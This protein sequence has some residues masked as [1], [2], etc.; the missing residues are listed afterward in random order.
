MQKMWEGR[1]KEAS[2]KLLEDFNASISFDKALYKEDINGSIAHATMLCEC[3]ILTNDEKDKICN[4]LNQILDEIK[5]NKF[6]FKIEDEDI[7]MAVEKRLSEI[8][9][10]EIGGKL[11]TARSRN[12]Q[13]ALDF[14]M[15]VL[16]KNKEISN[17]LLKLIKTLS[18]LM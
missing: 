11:H 17:L 3:G 7:H 2:S 15:F 8:I 14:R 13:V 10:K 18:L 6:E 12:D 16:N 9:G 1:F 5:N 4:G